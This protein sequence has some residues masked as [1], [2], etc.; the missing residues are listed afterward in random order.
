MRKWEV[1]ESTGLRY[2]QDQG[3]ITA[4]SVVA[5]EDQSQKADIIVNVWIV[6][7]ALK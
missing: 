5:P 3:R 2:K 6:R 1:Q 7:S 4:I